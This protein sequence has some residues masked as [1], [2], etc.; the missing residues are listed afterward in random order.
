MNCRS[1]RCALAAIAST[2]LFAGCATH[3]KTPETERNPAPAEA[4]SKFNSFELLPINS[5]EACVKQHGADVALQQMQEQLTVRLGSVVTNWNAA[6]TKTAK[7]RKLVIEPV[8]SDAK[9]VGTQARIWGGALAGSSA[10]VI[11]VRYVDASTRKVIAEPVFY[12]RANAMGAAW[13]FG[14]T[15][16]SM[17]TRLVDL[18]TDYTTKNYQIAVGGATGL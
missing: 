15:D 6:H 12:Q 5:G 7:P 1:T 14:A 11:K 13:S 10:V 16:R 4:F 18:I 9:L 17:V 3:V 2:A 8:C